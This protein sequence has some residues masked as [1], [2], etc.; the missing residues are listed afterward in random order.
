MGFECNRLYFFKRVNAKLQSF[1]CLIINKKRKNA[2]TKTFSFSK[3]SFPVSFPFRGKYPKGDRGRGFV[4][5]RLCV[6]KNI[7]YNEPLH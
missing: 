4:S 7:F 2:K 3:L 6:Q 5:L 1:K